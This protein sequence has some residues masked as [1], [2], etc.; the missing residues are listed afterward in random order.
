MVDVRRDIEPRHGMP[1]PKLTREEFHRRYFRQFV[2]PAFDRIR[3]HLEEAAEIAWGAYE[4]SRKAPLTRK[5][6]LEFHDPDYDLS[7]D[8]I[9]AREAI[10]KAKDQHDDQ[11]QSPRVLL[12]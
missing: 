1:S 6:G 9:E 4:G 11:G 2:D 5:A 8:W 7:V 10:R 12:I 3:R